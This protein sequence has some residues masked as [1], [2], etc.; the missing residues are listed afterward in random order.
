MEENT[1]TG[2][3]ESKSRVLDELLAKTA[4]KDSLRL[5]LKSIDPGNSPHLVRTLLGRDIEVPLAVAGALPVLANC[6]I[7]A[8]HELIVQIREKF[9]PPLLASFVES[10]LDEIDKETLAD[11]IAEARELKNDLAPLFIAVWQVIQDRAARRE[12]NI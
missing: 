7:K 3:I 11:L 10:L 6:F 9:P 4:F 2:F 5:F 1:N 8:G 12:E